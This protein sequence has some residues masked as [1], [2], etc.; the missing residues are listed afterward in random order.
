MRLPF[1]RP[2][3]DAGGA[4]RP[5]LAGDEPGSLQAARIQ[6]RRRL[7]GAVVL[8]VVAVAGFP[9]LFETQPR[10]M[11]GKAAGD[12]SGV[13]IR[14]EGVARGT[15]AE[16]AVAR[17]DAAKPAPAGPAPSSSTSPS[18]SSSTSASTEPAAEPA[19]AG[20]VVPMASA[21]LVAAAAP[22]AAASKP[23]LAKKSESAAAAPLKA[24]A[25][26]P[27][28][29]RAASAAAAAK[30]EKIEKSDKADK[31]T[32]VAPAAGAEA[33]ERWVV[34]VGAYNDMERMRQARQKAEKL[35]F[36]TYTTEVDTPTGKRTRVRLGP[37]ATKKDAD[38]A[39]AKVKANGMAANVLGL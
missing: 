1:L 20:P 27:V 25:P 11:P 38:A 17:A 2:P 3:S 18:T 6:A 7:M 26:P 29:A 37:F 14:G 24:T 5:S 8:L 39:A 23:V 12:G 22:V 30:P 4:D 10:S 13:V 36:K 28:P 32:P 9:L 15:G 33:S 34:Q 19:A 35:G 31:A 21:P 16:P